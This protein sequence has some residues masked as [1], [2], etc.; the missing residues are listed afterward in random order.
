MNCLPQDLQKNNV[1]ST[2][3]E[4]VNLAN[5]CTVLFLMYSHI[6]QLVNDTYYWLKKYKYYYYYIQISIRFSYCYFEGF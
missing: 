6:I 4:S 2:V 1:W 3:I 5:D